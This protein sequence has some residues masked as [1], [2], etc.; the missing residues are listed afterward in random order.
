MKL[1]HE[2]S[3]HHTGIM[4]SDFPWVIIEVKMKTQFSIEFLACN[5]IFHLRSNSGTLAPFISGML[6]VHGS[7]IDLGG[8]N[9]LR[10]SSEKHTVLYA[11]S[12]LGGE[13]SLPCAIAHWVGSGFPC[14]IPSKCARIVDSVCTSWGHTVVSSSL[15]HLWVNEW[16]IVEVHS[17]LHWS[18]LC[19]ISNF[20]S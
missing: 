11:A 3:T 6:V 2:S 7:I 14:L 1:P 8:S 4:D 19:S 13:S 12:S 5:I 20:S 15:E 10:V 17:N 16:G 18:W 9:S